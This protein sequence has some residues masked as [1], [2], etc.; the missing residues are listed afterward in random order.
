[1]A[2]NNPDKKALLRKLPA[3]HEILKWPGLLQAQDQGTLTRWALRQAAQTVLDSQRSA[4]LKNERTEPDSKEKLEYAIKNEARKLL[5]GSLV[6][7]INATGVILHT[8]LGRAP[9][10]PEALNAIKAVAKGY[11]NLEFDLYQ[12]KRGQRHR[13]VEGLLCD[14]TGAEAALV[15][16]NNAAAVFLALRVL[17]TDKEVIV[18]H[19]FLKPL[20]GLGKRSDIG[21]PEE[22]DRLLVV[23]DQ[24]E[25]GCCS[26]VTFSAESGPPLLCQ[27]VQDPPLKSARVLKL[28]HKDMVCM[29]IEI[30]EDIVSLGTEGQRLVGQKLKV[31]EVQDVT[32]AL[33]TVTA[34]CWRSTGA[35]ALR[36]QAGSTQR[37]ADDGVTGR[38]PAQWPHRYDHDEPPGGDERDE[39]RP[40][41]GAA[42][43][44]AHLPR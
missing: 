44:V 5:R 41:C 29:L 1:M 31:V 18:S 15:V 12:G 25:G 43:G 14:L 42:S 26:G 33:L 19:P 28:I 3:V 21:P 20:A 8:N 2:N 6:P 16:N 23:S 34:L 35:V 10:A 9:L 17:A 38:L 30:I 4:L 37:E 27:A 40:G 39:R 7:V 36:S 13:H 24:K 32:F 11:S 22:V